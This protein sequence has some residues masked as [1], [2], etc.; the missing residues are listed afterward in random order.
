MTTAVSEPFVVGAVENVT[1]YGISF[2]FVVSLVRSTAFGELP[3]HADYPAGAAV[4]I[5][6]A[7]FQ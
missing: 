6:R 4:R 5:T 2:T 7:P 3:N 1:A